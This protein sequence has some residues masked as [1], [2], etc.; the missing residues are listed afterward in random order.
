[1]ATS[2][3]RNAVWDAMLESEYQRRY[4]HSKASQFSKREHFLQVSLAVLSSSAVLTAL[5]DLQQLWLWKVLS[6]F[7]AIVATTQ[8]F[9]NYTRLS[10]KMFN[11]GTQWHQLE[12][13]YESMWRSIDNGN[14]SEKK[15]KELRNKG[16]EIYN[17]AADLPFDDNKIQKACYEQVLIGRGLKQ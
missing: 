10:I 11:A 4:W 12:L 16:V 8:P 13:E 6:A 9:L 2:V 3:E 17:T 7:T 15:F 1:M 14:Y 5:G